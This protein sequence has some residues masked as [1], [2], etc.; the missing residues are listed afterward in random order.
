MP[1]GSRAAVFTLTVFPFICGCRS[2][3]LPVDPGTSMRAGVY[4]GEYAHGPNHAVVSVGIKDG[5]IETV[6]LLKHRRSWKGAKAGA[7]IVERIIEHQSPRVDAVTGATNSSRV[8]MN[9]V[10]QAL[11]KARRESLDSSLD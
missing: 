7:L 11:D 8:I 4:R 5:R 1:F 9:A 2:A 3:P 10:Q 6:Q